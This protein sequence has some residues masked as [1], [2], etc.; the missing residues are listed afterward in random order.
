M[1]LRYPGLVPEVTRLED[2]KFRGYPQEPQL[3][4]RKEKE[5][6]EL[7]YPSLCYNPLYIKQNLPKKIQ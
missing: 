7:H 4:K 6:K 3:K 1:D 5:N 2:V